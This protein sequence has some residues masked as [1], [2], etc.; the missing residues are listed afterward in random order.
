MVKAIIF[1]FFGVLVTEGFKLF[2]D[3]HFP[4]DE[5]KWQ[6]AIELVNKHD[7][8]LISKAQ[9][10]EGMADISGKSID[11]VAESINSNKPNKL[12]IE[13]IK[14]E[15]KPKYK[16][17]VLSNSGDDYLSQMLDPSDAKMFDDVILSYRYGMIK[18]QIEIFELAAERLGVLTTECV[19]I[20][21]S[22][23]HCQGAR[24]A[25][26]KTIHYEDFPS[27]KKQIAKILSTV[28]DN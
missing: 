1:D 27:F 26:M 8:G 9:F 11:F 13:Y 25:G 19:F 5:Q 15:L 18:P 7:S 28:A 24:R 2:R 22:P 20:D 14:S 21:D 16:I 17:G 10:I 4:D 3:T 6:A 23:S 12:L